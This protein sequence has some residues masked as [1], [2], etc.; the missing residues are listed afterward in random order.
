MDH[1]DISLCELAFSVRPSPRFLP[2]LSKSASLRDNGK[3]PAT[4]LEPDIGADVGL[5]A[6]DPG[7]AR[8]LELLPC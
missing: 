3:D 6:V 8:K 2:P 5:P 7:K 4:R 1:H